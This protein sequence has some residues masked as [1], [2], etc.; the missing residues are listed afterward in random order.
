LSQVGMH[1]SGPE[2]AMVR[3]NTGACRPLS[4]V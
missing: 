4:K 1:V 2:R 3:L